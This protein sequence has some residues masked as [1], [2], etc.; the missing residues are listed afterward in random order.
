MGK[1]RSELGEG[2][3]HCSFL[4]VPYFVLTNFQRGVH[5]F[6]CTVS[7]GPVTC[8]AVLYLFLRLLAYSVMGSCLKVPKI[9]RVHVPM[10]QT[11]KTPFGSL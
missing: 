3:K 1:E 5:L 8:A 6:A 10:E 2:G 7:A 4:Q 11:V 9:N